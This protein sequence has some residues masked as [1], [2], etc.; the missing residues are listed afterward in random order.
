MAVRNWLAQIGVTMLYVVPGALE[1][2]YNESFD[3]S[4]RDARLNGDI[5]YSLGEACVLIGAPRRHYIPSARTEVCATDHRH[6][7]V[8]VCGSLAQ[9]RRSAQWIA[10]RPGS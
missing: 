6:R 9:R 7:L 10:R 4:L 1:N 5:F 2:G 3:G 8:R